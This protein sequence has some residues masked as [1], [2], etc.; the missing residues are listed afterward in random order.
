MPV[1]VK[2]TEVDHGWADIR[3]RI[4]KLG[5]VG[6]GGIV[7]IGVQGAQAAA[8]HQNSKLT[9][10]QIANIHEYGKVIHQPKKKRTIV[11]PARSFIGATVDMFVEAIARREALLAS[12][13]MM[14]KFTLRGGLD[15]FGQYVVGLIVQR[16]ADRIPPP[17]SKWT[18]A[19]KR[20]TVP[21]IDSGQ[22]RGSITHKIEGAA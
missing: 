12:G 9:T 7:R 18:I 2:V 20:S 19:R 10:A 6:G 17:L 21:L 14:G 3:D 11:I 13:V 16:I 4:L 5:Q 8:N 1:T 15:L 22:L